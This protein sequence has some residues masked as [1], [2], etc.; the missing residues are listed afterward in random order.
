[1]DV[2]IIYKNQR[3]TRDLPVVPE[4]G[5]RVRIVIPG[6]NATHATVQSRTW[7]FEVGKPAEVEIDCA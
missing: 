1:M 6:A 5:E 4:V 2:T 7:V 3:T